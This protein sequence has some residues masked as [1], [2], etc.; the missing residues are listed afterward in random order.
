MDGGGLKKLAPPLQSPLSAVHTHTH[1]HTRLWHV[2]GDGAEG[3]ELRCLKGHAARLAQC[4]FHPTG[5][6]LGT[7]SWD[8]TWR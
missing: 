5:K 1:T 3:Q 7:T 6:F 8:H 2:S 4:A